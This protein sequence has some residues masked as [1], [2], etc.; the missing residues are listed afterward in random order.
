MRKRAILYLEVLPFQLRSI[1]TLNMIYQI[2]DSLL[3]K[4]GE[5]GRKDE[6][7]A[8]LPKRRMRH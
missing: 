5:R 6:K 7:I 1:S 3:T 4:L 8:N 2:P